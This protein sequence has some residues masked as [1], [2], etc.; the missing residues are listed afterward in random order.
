MA[1]PRNNDERITITADDARGSLGPNR[2]TVGDTLLPMLIGMIVL[3][4]VGVFVV[5]MVIW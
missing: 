5:L 1:E 4:I 2:G 3:T